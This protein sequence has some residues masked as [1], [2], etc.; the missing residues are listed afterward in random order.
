MRSTVGDHYQ[1]LPRPI[2]VML[3]EFPDGTTT[4]R[5]AHLRAQL[6]YAIRGLMVANTARGAWAVPPGQALWIPPGVEHDIAMHGAVSMR[7]AYIDAAAAQLGDFRLLQVSDL[8][9]AALCALGE[10]PLLYDPD[11]RGGHLEALILDEIARAPSTGATLPMAA[12]A[13]L[14]RMCDALL[15]NP[16]LSHDID[17][18]ADRVGMSRRTL[19]RTFRSET[20]LSFAEWRRRLRALAVLR[21]QAGGASLHKAAGDVG[22]RS[23]RALKVM[24]R[25]LEK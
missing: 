3:K 2:G 18:W 20:G 11:G 5:H 19:T 24:M 23:P 7:T 10:L 4:G 9:R 1:D 22:Y 6:L 25:R 12:D 14:K 15:E 8:L 17:E 13:R 16:S 21:S